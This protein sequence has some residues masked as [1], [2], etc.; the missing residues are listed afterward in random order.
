MII[1]VLTRAPERAWTVLSTR[2]KTMSVMVELWRK[3]GDED[4]VRH[5]PKTDELQALIDQHLLQGVTEEPRSSSLTS[6]L[7]SEGIEGARLS[8]STNSNLTTSKP[9]LMNPDLRFMLSSLYSKVLNVY[10]I[11]SSSS[12]AKD[13]IRIM[14]KRDWI[15]IQMALFNG[16]G[17][18]TQE[19]PG[20]R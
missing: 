2:V 17:N 7:A 8:Y 12:K 19:L 4:E 9:N 18:Q 6:T 16:Y 10:R 3:E 5:D 15:S 14:R 11:N 1:V 13:L 20:R